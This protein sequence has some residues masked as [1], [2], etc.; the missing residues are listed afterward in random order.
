MHN[1][2]NPHD[3]QGPERSTA[4]T[5]STAEVVEQY[6]AVI[7]AIESQPRFAETQKWLEVIRRHAPATPRFRLVVSGTGTGSVL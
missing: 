7:T 4:S 3:P 2:H 5:P 1:P 6:E